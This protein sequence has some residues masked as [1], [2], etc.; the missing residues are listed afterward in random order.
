MRKIYK[1][2][3]NTYKPINKP[4]KSFKPQ[5]KDN[6][7]FID[8]KNT[9]PLRNALPISKKVL[10]DGAGRPDGVLDGFASG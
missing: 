5:F 1:S 7:V 4:L 10:V 6:E 8:P 9:I 3:N 2:A